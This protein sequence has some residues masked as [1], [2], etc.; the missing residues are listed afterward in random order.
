MWTTKIFAPDSSGNDS[1]CDETPDAIVVFIDDN[2]SKAN[3][4]VA[5]YSK[6]KYHVSNT[7]NV[8]DPNKLR[9]CLAINNRRSI[10]CFQSPAGNVTV[11]YYN[12]TDCSE[13][14]NYLNVPASSTA[15]HSTSA[16]ASSNVPN[17]TSTPI[18]PSDSSV[19]GSLDTLSNETS[20]STGAIIGIVIGVLV[21]VL[22]VAWFVWY[23]RRFTKNGDSDADKRE[24]AYAQASSPKSDQKSTDTGVTDFSSSIGLGPQSLAG[25]WDDELIATSR[26]PRDKVLVQ[27]LIN[28]GGYG[29]VYY[30]LYN[31]Q[32]VALKTLLPELRKSI[33]HVNQLLDEVRLLAM[34]DHPRVVHFVGI[35]WDSLSD[36][37][38]VLEYMEGGDL[39]A[40]LASYE[41]QGHDVGFDHT[42]VTIALHVA[43]ALTYLHSLD[44]PVLHRDLKSKNVLL[45]S[46]LQAKITDFGISRERADK[47]MTAGV[48]TSLW[49]VPEVMMGERYDDKADMFSFGVMLSE[50]DLHTLP[51]SHAKHNLSSSGHKMPDTTILQRVALGKIRVEF[52]PGALDSMV[53]LANS[54]VALD[55]KYRPTAA[56]ALYHLQT[57]LREL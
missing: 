5:N 18:G 20:S 57:V 8:T 23:R 46:D 7:C 51:Y 43:H 53:A 36:L 39:R 35:A 1:T 14:N 29:E 49:M 32:R 38:I 11:K 17:P 12:A 28:R 19:S 31:G 30:G 40:L 10:Q 56:E 44:S 41:A 27:Q 3:C 6:Y 16:S 45:T 50:L 9:R 37:C 34:L 48:G 13:D 47:T 24:G 21:A 25:L 33:K 15:S 2:C 26:I 42:K 55:P 52:S 4:A 22:V 54:C